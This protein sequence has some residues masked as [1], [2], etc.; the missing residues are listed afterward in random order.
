MCIYSPM[1]HTLSYCALIGKGAL[2]RSNTVIFYKGDNC[3]RLVIAFL[4]RELFLQWGYSCMHFKGD[5]SDLVLICFLFH[6][7][8]F[9]GKDFAV[10]ID[11]FT[12][13]IFYRR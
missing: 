6:W 1:P 13:V 4:L 10:S 8:I 12:D 11:C 7:V 3:D 9:K 2:I 5:H